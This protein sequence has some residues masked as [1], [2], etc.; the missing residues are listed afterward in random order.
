MSDKVNTAISLFAVGLSIVA[1]LMVL[2]LVFMVVS[3]FVGWL[4]NDSA[5]ALGGWVG[6]FLE[7]IND[8][9]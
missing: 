9:L 6:D 5:S 1:G 7:A 4:V 3:G 8:Q 2:Y